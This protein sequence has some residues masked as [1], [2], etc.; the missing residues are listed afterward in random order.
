MEIKTLIIIKKNRK[1]F[2]ATINGYKCKILIDS[3]SEALE[4]GELDLMV[5]DISVRSKY[6]VD[7]IFKLAFHAEEQ[8]QAQA[9]ICTLKHQFF[10]VLLVNECRNLGGRWDKQ[11]NVWVFSC[12]VEDRVELLDEKFNSEVL[13]IEVKILNAVK[14][15]TGAYCLFGMPIVRAFDR[16]SG[17]KLCEG[18][19]LISGDIR[20]SGSSKY[21]DTEICG[22]SILRFQVP[23][24]LFDQFVDEYTGSGNFEFKIL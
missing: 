3:N 24:L 18:V 11:E 8:T 13:D 21:W 9:G 4:L 16:D 6:G 7:I 14:Q 15:E 12:I 23:K 22:N 19:A 20:S 17:A 1:F 5:E 10:N 2:A